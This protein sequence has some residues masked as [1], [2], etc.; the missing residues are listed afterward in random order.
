MGSTNAL[1]AVSLTSP[2]AMTLP[3]ITAASLTATSTAGGITLSGPLAITGTAALNAAEDIVQQ[4]AATIDP[5]NLSMVSTTGGITLNSSV[6]ATGSVTL[7]AA[8]DI[9]EIAGAPG[10]VLLPSGSIATP[11]LSATS[12]A[13]RVV[14]TLSNT[15]D[16][17]SGSAP[18]GFS[19]F[20]S[21]ALDVG[22]AGISSTAGSVALETITG[23]ITQTGAV[24]GL[25]LFADAGSDGTGSV[26]LN[27]PN[28]A[29]GLLAGAASG[30]LQFT[31]NN[32]ADLAIGT[33]NYFTSSDTD[34]P[35]SST[36]F[37][38]SAL[39]LGAPAPIIQISNVGNLVFNSANPAFPDV[40]SVQSFDPTGLIILAATR[41][42]TN[43]FGPGAIVESAIDPWQIYSASPTGDFFNDLDSGNTA[44]WNTTFG[45]PVTAAGN[46]YIFA[47]QP[48]ITV[49][50]GDLTKT[51]G[52]DV[53]SLVAADFSIS[54]L[55]PG[56]AG[57][58]LPDAAAA[59]TSGT[60]SVAS[61]GSPA[62]ASVAGSPYAV[63][64]APGSFAVSDNYALVLDSAGRLTV[65]PLPLTYSVADARSIFGTT[66]ILGAATLFGV[67][68]GD[69]VDPTVGAFRGS[70]Q[71]PL[72]PFTPVGQYSQMV[73]ALSNPNY[74]IAASGNSPGTLTVAPTTVAFLPFDPG[75]LPGLTQINNP[76]QT[77]YDVGGYEQVL[78][79]F[80][81]ACNEPPSLPD[82]NAYSDPDAALRAISQAM[83]N[84]FRRCQN[85]TQATIA[86]ALDAYAA[87]LQILAPR[88]PPALR[89]VPAIIAQAAKRV[90][91]APTRAAAVAVLRQT[92]AEVHKE[93]ALVLSEDPQTRSREILDG[94]VIAGALG[95]A[96]VALVNS[97]GL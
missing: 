95:D 15:V 56:V 3:S 24:R 7:T 45:E 72:N 79:H 73:T 38:V 57:A 66:P 40:P 43:N 54:G 62:R 64:V 90:R 33:V 53:T 14:L 58:F 30:D 36:A 59:V 49:T 20:N 34:V 27:N 6:T 69:T 84:Y 71:I 75:F 17:V 88:L 80:S 8:N 18:A 35:A 51:Y 83:E 46:R 9:I 28:N 61:L 44:V 23:S 37:G 85:L 41:N 11:T 86:D 70:L 16:S 60:P 92:V 74:V 21:G 22:A 96:N 42:F 65:D 91:A 78:P 25:A 32:G 12:S 82:P 68:P 89:N 67:L 48:T 4:G 26:V 76:A 1:A 93:I 94:D 13:G 5:T 10:P 97:G 47:F 31:N 2:S 63:T 29:V 55:Q 19:F 52:Q 81:V 77:E 87:K 39:G 50:S